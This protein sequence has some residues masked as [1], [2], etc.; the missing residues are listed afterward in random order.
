[1][2]GFLLHVGATV[3]CSHAGQ[4]VPTVPNARVLVLG[5]PTVTLSAPYLVGGC[6]LPP[7][8]GGPCVTG[9]WLLGSTRVLSDGQPLVLQTGL[10][11]SAPT[12]T[13]L[14]ALVCQTRVA[15]T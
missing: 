15:A 4:A 13:P 9:Q 1:M 7:V 3:I 2:P 12:G 5:M 14:L 10:A 8:L 6:A 11:I